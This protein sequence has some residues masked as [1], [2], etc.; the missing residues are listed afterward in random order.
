[1]TFEEY[2]QNPMGKD[3]A[4]MSNRSMYKTLYTAKFD[5]VMVREAGNIQYK[6]YHV[7]KRYI[8]YIKIPSEVVAKFYYDVLIE[9]SPGKG[10]NVGNDLKKYNVRFFSNDPSFVYTF[11]HA[12]IKNKIF[13]TDFERK[14][15]KKAIKNV[16]KM[17]NPSDQVGYVKSLYFAYIAMTRKGLFSK[18][19]Y[20]DSYSESVLMKEVMH[21]DK[22]IEARQMGA[23]EVSKKK[24]QDDENLKAARSPSN[25]QSPEVPIKAKGIGKVGSVKRG[26]SSKSIGVVKKAKKR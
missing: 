14:M 11:A 9:F 15:S 17:K 23:S 8:C 20:V 16:A 5:K 10:I 3:T 24:K 21:A 12:F 1:M 7:G 19:R 26:A 2:I 22:K 6:A 4:V 13:F 18:T 25:T